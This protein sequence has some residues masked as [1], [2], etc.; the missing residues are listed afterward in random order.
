MNRWCAIFA[1]ASLAAAGGCG[2]SGGGGPTFIALASDFDGFTAWYSAALPP[3]PLSATVDPAGTHVGFLNRRPP[4]GAKSY[5]V[6]TILVKAIEPAADE[7]TWEMFGMAKRGGGF[8]TGGADADGWEYFLLR[9]DGDGNPYITSRGLMPANDGSDMG[10]G[11]Y[12]PGGAA[13]GCNYC[14]GRD[15]YAP[16]DHIISPPLIPAA[17][18]E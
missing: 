2:G 12:A 18:A 8:N 6:G 17:T 9:V 10:A 1:V 7:T 4:L 13:G 11:A 16:T 3:N 14:H 5:P 15:A